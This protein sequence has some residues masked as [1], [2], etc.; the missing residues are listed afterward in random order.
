MTEVLVSCHLL[1]EKKLHQKLYNFSYS[2]DLDPVGPCYYGLDN[3]FVNRVVLYLRT[4]TK[5]SSLVAVL[6]ILLNIQYSEIHS[7]AFKYVH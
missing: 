6:V 5:S 7:E 2:L 4:S 3:N 1:P